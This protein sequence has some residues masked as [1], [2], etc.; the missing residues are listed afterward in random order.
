MNQN[1][2]ALLKRIHQNRHTSVN[3]EFGL[4]ERY[5]IEDGLDQGETWSPILWRIFYN[6]LLAEIKYREK[7]LRYNITTK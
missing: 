7:I 4:T 6:S 2:I 5:T 3:T 1:F